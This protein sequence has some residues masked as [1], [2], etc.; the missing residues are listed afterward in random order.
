[1][2]SQQANPPFI[3]YLKEAVSEIRFALNARQYELALTNM[4]ITLQSL[5]PTDQDSESGKELLDVLHKAQEF[6]W[7]IFSKYSDPL[8][9]EGRV[10]DYDWRMKGSYYQYQ[11]ALLR[12]LWKGKYWEKA[13][14]IGVIPAQTL[15]KTSPTPPE[16]PFPERLT[17]E[18]Q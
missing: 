4:I 5:K 16:T 17:E 10:G 2:E 15:Q 12:I 14:Y 6:R 3:G 13:S 1:M 11:R 7:R 8:I 18:L 9:A